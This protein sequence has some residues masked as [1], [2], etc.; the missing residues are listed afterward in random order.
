MRAHVLVVLAVGFALAGATSGVAAQEVP[1][2]FL[3]VNDL[4]EPGALLYDEYAA[5]EGICYEVDLR[6]SAEIAV[7]IVN[8]TLPL[9]IDTYAVEAFEVNGIGKEGLDNGVLI[10]VSTDERQWRV[11]VGYG[12]EGILNDG[13]VGTIGRATLTP[14]LGA[15]DVYGGIRDATLA[16]GQE[17]VDNYDPGADPYGEPQLFVV[18]WGAVAIAV[19]V[20]LV[21][22]VV[23]KGRAIL[24]IGAL[25][26]FWKRGSFGGGRSGGGGARG[27]F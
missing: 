8:T 2:I 1:T 26:S 4:T 7:L 3:Y 25:L 12:L 5:I 9:G 14:S 20:F 22:A 27:R 13:K 16:I 21:V 11:E 18:D 23:T 6:T 24:W 10:L 17:I 19:G 15:D